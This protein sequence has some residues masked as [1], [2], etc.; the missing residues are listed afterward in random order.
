M[1]QA[2]RAFSSLRHASLE[3]AAESWAVRPGPPASASLVRSAGFQVSA[4]RYVVGYDFLDSTFLS[5][6][7]VVRLLIT[8]AIVSTAVFLLPDLRNSVS[9][10]IARSRLEQSGQER[11]HRQSDTPL[12]PCWLPPHAGAVGGGRRDKNG[13]AFRVRSSDCLICDIAAFEHDLG[14]SAEVIGGER[15][16]RARRGRAKRAVDSE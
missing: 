11:T 8:C 2:K 5:P 13:D 6:S 9:K 15:H 14:I 10:K 7:L 3:L 16:S 12:S 1:P 4:D